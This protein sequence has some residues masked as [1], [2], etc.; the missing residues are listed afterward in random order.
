LLK[1]STDQADP[2]QVAPEHDQPADQVHSAE[3]TLVS[4]EVLR[5][6]GDGDREALGE[7]FC[8][9]QPVLLRFL[10]GL[11]VTHADDIAGQVWIEVARS[12]PRFEGGDTEFRRWLFTIARRRMIDAFR[13]GE[14]RMEDPVGEPPERQVRDAADDAAGSVEW[15][16]RMLRRLPRS[17]AEVVLL[18]TIVGLSV[19]EVAVIVQRSPGAVRVL[20]HRGLT[21]L[22]ELL[23]EEEDLLPAG[24]TRGRPPSMD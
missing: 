11:A 1:P 15:A 4:T 23:S 14:R 22:R 2:S 10:R 8:A 6:A 9:F 20:A 16:E 17:Q 21:R 13:A 19:D 24:V 7:V 3:A 5:R 12:L 18:R